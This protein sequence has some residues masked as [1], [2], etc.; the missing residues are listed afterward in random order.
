MSVICLR[1]F[2]EERLIRSIGSAAVAVEPSSESWSF[3]TIENQYRA[4]FGDQSLPA[5]VETAWKSTNV[6]PYEGGDVGNCL[7][8]A[9]RIRMTRIGR[10]NRPYPF[11]MPMDPTSNAIGRD[12]PQGGNDPLAWMDMKY[13]NAWNH[14]RERRNQSLTIRTRSDL[15]AHDEYLA[16][17]D[18]SFHEVFIHVLTDNE[19]IG[20]VIEPG[21]PSYKR[22]IQAYDK[23]K[24]LGFNVTLVHD[25]FTNSHKSACQINR[26]V[27]QINEIRLTKAARI[28]L[29]RA[30]IDPGGAA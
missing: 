4:R 29:N 9:L 2:R 18:K 24:S 27:S 25:R 3:E 20:R 5:W 14:I 6:E 16:V 28:E 19:E 11:A 1:T 30:G 21:C 17:L 7:W 10:W 8:S 15:I 26:P 23:L 22:R 13:R 12:V